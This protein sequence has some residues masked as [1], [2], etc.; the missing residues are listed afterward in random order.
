[1]S[2]ASEQTLNESACD[3]HILGKSCETGKWCCMDPKKNSTVCTPCKDKDPFLGHCLDRPNPTCESHGYKA[4]N[5]LA[6]LE[7]YA[8]N[9]ASDAIK[10]KLCSEYPG[11]PFCS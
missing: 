11:L 3:A 9:Y 6:D 2:K 4:W 7:D 5:D 1:M 8:Y 10:A